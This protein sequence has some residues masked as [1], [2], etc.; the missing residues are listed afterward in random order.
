MF[1]FCNICPFCLYFQGNTENME[2]FPH[3]FVCGLDFSKGEKN[4][5]EY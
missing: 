1:L 2:R 5:K 4:E 3:Q